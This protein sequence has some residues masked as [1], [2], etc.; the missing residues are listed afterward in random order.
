[1]RAGEQVS[2]RNRSNQRSPITERGFVRPSCCGSGDFATPTTTVPPNAGGGDN[3]RVTGDYDDGYG[4]LGSCLNAGKCIDTYVAAHTHRH[5][6]SSFLCV[7]YT[8]V[9]TT[10]TTWGGWL[11]VDVNPVG[12]ASPRVP[13]GHTGWACVWGK[14]KGKR[15]PRL[16]HER[17]RG[18]FIHFQGR[19]WPTIGSALVHVMPCDRNRDGDGD[20]A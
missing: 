4:D 6:E 14:G 12:F 20:G 7:V 16:G 13:G 10:S 3:E 9:Y 5:K 15:E 17:K 8:I 11:S 2:R 19:Y 1:M 18:S